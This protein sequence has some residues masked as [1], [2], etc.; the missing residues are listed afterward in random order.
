M[1]GRVVGA[2]HKLGFEPLAAQSRISRTPATPTARPRRDPHS[3][4]L[5]QRASLS[6]VTRACHRPHFKYTLQTLKMHAVSKHQRDMFHLS[7]ALFANLLAGR[8]A[9]VCHAKTTRYRAPK[10]RIRKVR[11]GGCPG[12]PPDVKGNMVSWNL[13][14]H[15]PW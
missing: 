9:P 13:G 7:T 6:L 12:P 14:A 11:V 10:Y 8:P 3:G 1:G 15:A 4:S 5:R 2:M